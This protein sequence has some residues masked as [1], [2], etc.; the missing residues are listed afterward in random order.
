MGGL[1]GRLAALLATVKLPRRH[2]RRSIANSRPDRRATFWSRT[3][4]SRTS[5][6]SRRFRMSAIGRTGAFGAVS[7]P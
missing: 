5:R 3:L 4:A 6:P 7:T 1:R 2:L